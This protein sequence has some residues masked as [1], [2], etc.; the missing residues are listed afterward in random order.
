MMKKLIL[1]LALALVGCA[2]DP[3]KP[4]QI[5]VKQTEYVMRI[6]PK[7]LMTLPP[8]VEKIDIDAA[9]QSDI[10]RWLIANEGR[11]TKLEEL[12]KQ[13]A[14]FFTIEQ[15]KLKDKADEENK[16]ARE[17]AAA[18]QDAA[19]KDAIAKPVLK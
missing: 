9:K 13:I 8:A 6:P 5:I 12:L 4:E 11:T 18:A 10:A 17:S 3:P 19:T 1:I 15:A 7:E 14:T 16:K 2:S